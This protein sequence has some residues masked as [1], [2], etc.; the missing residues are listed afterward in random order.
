MEALATNVGH[1][2]RAK[3]ILQKEKM[4]DEYRRRKWS[5]GNQK[6]GQNQRHRCVI[7]GKEGPMQQENLGHTLKV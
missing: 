4:N 5:T 6:I 7:Y 3:K 2:L 1:T